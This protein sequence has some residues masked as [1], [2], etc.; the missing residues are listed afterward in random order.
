MDT[1]RKK[2]IFWIIFIIFGALYFCVKL[3]GGRLTQGLYAQG[4]FSLLNKIVQAQGMQPVDFYLGRMEE[5]VF[6]P[7]SLVISGLLFTAFSFFYLKDSSLKK[8]GLYV[9]LYLLI[10]KFEVLFFPPYGDAIGGPF[11]EAI[12]LKDHLFDYIGLYH[13]PG[14]ALGGPKVYL[15][16]LY[17][18]FLAILL[19]IIPNTTIFLIANHLIVFVF[20]A[21]IVALF[22]WMLLKTFKSETA[23]LAAIFLIS[24]PL[25]Q[26]QVEAINMEMS[27]LFFSMI[28]VVYLI[29]KKFWQ[30]VILSAVATLFKDTAVC[31]CAA[32]FVVALLV[33]FFD[34]EKKHQKG[35]LF[36]G[37]LAIGLAFIRVLLK[38]FIHDQ[39][40]SAG[41]INIL[42]GWPSLKTSP[43]FLSF[44]LSLVILAALGA[45]SV[46]HYFKKEKIKAVNILLKNYYA[47][48]VVF[49]Y[50]AMWFLLFINFYVVSPRYRILLYPFI[51]FC[52]VFTALKAV[53]R[54]SVLRRVMV[55]AIAIS[56]FSSYGL[57]F[58]PMEENDHVLLERSLEYRNDLKANMRLAKELEDNYSKY[59]I[60]A[61]FILAQLLALPELGY[62]K[63]PLDVMIYSMRC[64]YGNI[65]NFEGLNTIDITKTIWV[66]VKIILPDQV[67]NYLSFPIGMYDKVVKEIVAGNKKVTIF[68][69]GFAI[70]KMRRML[71]MALRESGSR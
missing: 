68:M 45:K 5:A 61:P 29:Q 64:T 54:E 15:F 40:V 55:G 56:F 25:F 53:K 18:T 14:Y 35:V 71:E 32:V 43:I 44:L 62:I 31:L 22:R 57:F 10:V 2:I 21:T 26:S 49:I 36:F 6:G 48:L 47:P 41:M 4:N 11:A 37:I 13:Q 30:A 38:Y 42:A 19:K 7:L 70:E 63:K 51:I 23:L 33:F 46:L 8:F 69:G 27:G 50:S 3:Q 65:K 12:W 17:P 9:F 39:H 1:P 59:T 24:L 28:A 67:K 20:A 58:T 60:G 52:V 34:E 16:S 66:G